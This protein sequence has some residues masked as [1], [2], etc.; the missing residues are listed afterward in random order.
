VV[1]G[2]EYV[3]AVLGDLAVRR[4]KVTGTDAVGG[5][6]SQVRA[7]VPAGELTSYATDLRS[8]GHGTG[9]FTRDPAG[10]TPVPAHLSQRVLAATR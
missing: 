1:V 10:Y 4:A 2:D 6:R 9:S 8:I 7:E 5:G 3:G